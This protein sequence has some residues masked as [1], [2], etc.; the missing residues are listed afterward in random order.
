MGIPLSTWEVMDP[1]RELMKI[2]L[3]EEDLSKRGMKDSVR[4]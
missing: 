3:G 1:T 4:K 2:I